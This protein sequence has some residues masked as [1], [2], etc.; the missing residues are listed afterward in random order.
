MGFEMNKIDH[1]VVGL[2]TGILGTAVGFAI[3]TI[4]WSTANGTRMEYFVQDVFLESNLY[5]DSILTISVLFNVGLFWLSLRFNLEKLAK[6]ILAVIF[7]SVPLIIY[8]Q[9]AAR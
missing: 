1:P 2:I 8:F 7:V 3:M 5:K 4:W 9:A 6:G